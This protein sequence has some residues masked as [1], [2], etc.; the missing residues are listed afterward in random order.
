MA[1]LE[2][3]CKMEIHQ[4]GTEGDSRKRVLVHCNLCTGQEEHRVWYRGNENDGRD[5]YS[6][7]GLGRRTIIVRVM[8]MEICKTCISSEAT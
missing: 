7:F 3:V 6:T 5:V 8:G 2:V 4:E 1:C